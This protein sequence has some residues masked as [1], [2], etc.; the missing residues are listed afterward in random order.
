MKK[1]LL[2]TLTIFLMFIFIGC[3]QDLSES[4]NTDKENDDL[5]TPVDNQNDDSSAENNGD[6]DLNDLEDD[7]NGNQNL[8]DVEDNGDDD[9]SNNEDDTNENDNQEEQD[10]IKQLNQVVYQSRRYGNRDNDYLDRLQKASFRL[11]DL[12]KTEGKGN[13]EN[14]VISPVSLYMSF[15]MLYYLGDETVKAE[16]IELLELSEEDMYFKERVFELLVNN[17]THSS[18]SVR[19]I[20]LINSIWLDNDLDINYNQDVLDALAN[21]LYCYA[22]EA[23]FQTDIQKANEAIRDFIKEKTNGAIDKNFNF[24]SETIFT[25]I[26][27][28][29]FKDAWVDDLR[30]LCSKQDVFHM[31]VSDIMCEYLYGKYFN[32]IEKSD[33][34]ARSMFTRTTNGYVLHFIVP[35]EGHTLDE[36]M[37]SNHLYDFLKI[38]S[39]TRIGNVYYHTR[40]IFPKYKVESTTEVKDILVNKNYLQNTSSMFFSDLTGEQPLAVG[41]I[42]H[43]VVLDVD[44]KGIEG[45]A[46][47]IMDIK[48]G[49]GIGGKEEIEEVFLDFV[50]DKNF[51]FVL[52]DPR[53]IVLFM[54][55]VTNPNA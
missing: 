29:Y 25:L 35:N 3:N 7:E 6:Q 12:I 22:Y 1:I 11:Y 42:R 9:N 8:D 47:T 24:S 39:P 44:K 45:A 15:A 49:A 26:N 21:E 5:V 40:V 2:I 17:L 52:C 31:D 46:V 28:I 27:T 33:E 38:D 18:Q 13:K 41:R 19:D 36:A 55:E 4:T 51:G 14:Y 48:A 20:D 54:G 34:I 16:I 23:P 30:E 43:D 53:G 10:V 50:V 32:G 37:D